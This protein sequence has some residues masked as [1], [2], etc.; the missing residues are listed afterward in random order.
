MKPN[1]R[2]KFLF[3]DIA[4]PSR[5]D[6]RRRRPDSA[7]GRKRSFFGKTE[8][9]LLERLKKPQS[10]LRLKPGRFKPTLFG[11][12]LGKTVFFFPVV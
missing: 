4:T 9:I 6:W 5:K 11:F 8:H 2:Q 12:S 1:K 10:F 7:L 3:K